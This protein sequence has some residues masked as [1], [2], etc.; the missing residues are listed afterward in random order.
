MR[1]EQAEMIKEA[2]SILE[3]LFP[4]ANSF[5]HSLVVGI[6][7]V[8]KILEKSIESRAEIEKH[9]EGSKSFAK[10]QEEFLKNI[11]QKIEDRELLGTVMIQ[12]NHNNPK[13]RIDACMSTMDEERIIQ[14]IS[15]FFIRYGHES[16]FRFLQHMM[17]QM[18]GEMKIVP[19]GFA[20]P[21]PT[22]DTEDES[23]TDMGKDEE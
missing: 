13:E 3:E 12:T 1:K 8:I 10:E 9:G 21:I 17:R 6:G 22:E 15:A 2:I 11:L 16:F 18:G 14:S 23:S 5:D 4:K 19:L 7:A 20:H